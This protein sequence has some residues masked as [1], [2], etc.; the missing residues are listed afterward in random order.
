MCTYTIWTLFS[1][2]LSDSS[3]QKVYY[4][5]TYTSLLSDSS[6]HIVY[7]F[8]AFFSSLLSNNSVNKV[9]IY[10]HSVC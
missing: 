9:Y 1:N 6:V 8:D 10:I 2:F 4:A 7:N 5:D 3:A